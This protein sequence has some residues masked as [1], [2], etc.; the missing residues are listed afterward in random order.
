MKKFIFAIIILSVQSFAATLPSDKARGSFLTIGVGP[1]VPLFGFAKT[2][3]LGYAFNV[4]F[5]YTD[6]EYLPV[7]LFSKIGF[8]QYPGDSD[9][10]LASEYSHFST[11]IIP[12]NLGARYFFA[13]LLENIILL[14]PIIEL[15]GSIGICSELHQFKPEALRNNFTNDSI[16]FGASAGI[17][18]SMF[19]MDLIG[20]YNYYNDNQFLSV[21]LKV[22]LPLFISF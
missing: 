3:T 14:M 11:T 7:F 9:F 13:P 22:R 10:Y 8:E 21:D 17:G 16:K 15:S 12:I 5:S 2:T 6:N 1:R 20:S 18:V 4:E 19:L